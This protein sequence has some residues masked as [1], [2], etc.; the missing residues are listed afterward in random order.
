MTTLTSTQAP[1]FDWKRW[2]RTEQFVADLL[3]SALD[4]SPF[5]AHIATRMRDETATRFE[6][7]I[8]HLVIKHRAGLESELDELGY[9]LD[10]VRYELNSPVYTHDGGIFPR[11]AVSPALGT[12]GSH[13]STLR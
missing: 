10:S 9:R 1:V 5:A 8:D 12:N 4:E 7:W 2:P 3:R 13:A 11:I 6:D